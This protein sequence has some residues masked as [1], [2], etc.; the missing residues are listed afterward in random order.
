M[1]KRLL[2]LPRILSACTCG[3]RPAKLLSMTEATCAWV[4]ALEKP[5]STTLP[6]LKSMPRLKPQNRIA[7]MPGMMT[8]RE[9]A[10]YQLRFLTMSKRPR[11][12]DRREEGHDDA[13]R[14]GDREA[15]DDVGAEERKDGAGDQR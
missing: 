10:K 5:T 8:A 14:E 1:A 13:D 15:P 11:D 3:R 9:P 2:S 12:R 6:P 7:R 4:T